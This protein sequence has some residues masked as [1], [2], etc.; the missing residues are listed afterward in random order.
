MIR[1]LVLVILQP[2]LI[3]G[4][5]ESFKDGEV[6]APLRKYLEKKIESQWMRKPLFACV[7]CM[8]SV[9]GAMTFFPVMVPEYGSQWWTLPLFLGDVFIL[10]YLNALI[11][12][13]L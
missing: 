3:N 2:F 11:Y 9:W 10:V 4:A 12:K 1:F 7:K 13:K 8:A 6:L 5:Y